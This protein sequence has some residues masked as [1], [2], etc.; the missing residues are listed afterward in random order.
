MKTRTASVL[1]MVIAL[2]VVLHGSRRV[3]GRLEIEKSH[4][5]YQDELALTVGRHEFGDDFDTGLCEPHGEKMVN[6]VEWH[7]LR[8]SCIMR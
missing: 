8:D 7:P 2:P 4:A 1:A 3:I 5:T 6:G